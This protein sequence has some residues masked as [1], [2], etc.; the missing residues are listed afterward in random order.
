[1]GLFSKTADFLKERLGKTRTMIASS[2]SSVLS[3]GRKIDDELLDELEETLIRDDIGVGT[4]E[5]LISELREAY[6]ARKISNSE[7]V[8]P[9]LKE[10]IKSYWPQQDRQLH[11][12]TSGPTV[13]LVAGVNGTGKTTSIAKLGYILHQSGK[14]VIVAACDT[15]RA[16]AVEQLTIWAERIGVQIVKHQAGSDPAAVAFDACD[17][18]IARGADIL[19]LD[20]AGRL[21]TKKDLMGQLTKIRDIVTRKIPG[22][23]HEVLLVLDGTT[24]QNAISQA[25]LFTEA[26]HVTGIFLAK[27]D[28]TAR[29]G[30]V[31]AIKD[32][33]DIPVKFVGLGEKP[34]D[35]A[36]FDPATFVE[37]LFA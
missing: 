4:T 35:I 33:L 29:G 19:I 3:L 18:A 20:T 36:E 9:F 16:A 13:I 15:F 7:E 1:M 24:G 12:A 2:L 22:A 10:H 11:L 17:A 23:P 32:Q 8:I 6:R 31:I 25:Q 27:L 34:T 5:K 37:A 30:I 21:H 26:I 14:K 28:G